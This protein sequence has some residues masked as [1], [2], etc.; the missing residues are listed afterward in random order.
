MTARVG[1]GPESESESTEAEVTAEQPRGLELRL[2]RP[3]SSEPWTVTVPQAVWQGAVALG[4]FLVVW[5]IGYAMPLVLHAR[6]VQLNQTSQDP[7][8]YT[9][10]LRWWP[11]AIAHGTNPF[12]TMQVGAPRGFNLA[13]TTTVPPLAVLASPITLLLGAVASFNLL[14]VLA[15]PVSAWAAFIACR[16][17]TGKFWGALLAGACYGFS[18]YEINHTAAGQ[19]NLTWNVLPPLMVYL[20]V[21]WRDGKLKPPW[22]VG[23]MGLLFLTQ[24]F[25]FLETFFELTVLLAIGLP[26][27]YAL[28]GRSARATIFRLGSLLALAYG[29]ALIVASPYLLYSLDH[30]PKGFTRSPAVTGLA[31]GNLIVPR[32]DR[33]FNI[34]WLLHFGRTLP[35]YAYA[36]YI[37]IPALL[38]IV[39]VA[40]W[41][42]RSRITRFLV[43]MFAVI[44]ALAIGPVFAFGGKAIGSVPWSHLWYLPVAR[45]ALPNRFM[46]MGD[47]VLALLVA[48]WLAAPLRSRFLH[49]GRW[50]LA[51]LAVIFIL[52]DVPTIADAQ[53]PNNERVPAFFATGEYRQYIE[54]GSTVLVISTRGNAAMLFQAYTNFYMRVAGGF[55]NMAITPRSDL[56]YQVSVLSH[57]TPRRERRFLAYLKREHIQDILVEKDWEP[58]WVG[59][60]HRMGLHGRS[61][62]GILLYR[63]KPC[64]THCDRQPKR[65]NA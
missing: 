62:G 36:D 56:P 64:L 26:L 2:P 48:I 57:A 32:V 10:S 22:F 55:I 17:L 30:Y 61:I 28:A 54:P 38:I 58:R 50:A 60:I 65:A 33:E 37:G 25:M 49:Y 29:A 19:L 3:G 40:I 14:V 59:V 53:P 9:W 12:Y 8:F 31:L 47:L 44:V 51:A 23:L 1:Y 45:S 24:L 52:A 39:G 18:A 5:I 11:Y 16:R 6:T 21:L 13:W 35:T 15:P 4:C 34:G 41:T 46:L 20:V 42:W 7:N 63:I 27:A 43:I